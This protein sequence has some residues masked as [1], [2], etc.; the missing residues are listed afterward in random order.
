MMQVGT[1]IVSNIRLA[2]MI[3]EVSEKPFGKFILVKSKLGG[4]R[5]WPVQSSMV[6]LWL[7]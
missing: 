5:Y 3:G 2:E 6:A 1:L 7:K 4:H